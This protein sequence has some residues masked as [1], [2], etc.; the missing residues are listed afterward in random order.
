MVCVGSDEFYDVTE[1]IEFHGFTI[2]TKFRA[3][4]LEQGCISSN[5]TENLLIR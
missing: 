2:A 3:Q 4:V 1:L 5:E